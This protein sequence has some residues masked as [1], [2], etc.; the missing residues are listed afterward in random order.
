[1]SFSATLLVCAGSVHARSIADRLLKEDGFHGGLIVYVAPRDAASMIDVATKAPRALIHGLIS[2]TSVLRSTRGDI[3][4][5]GRYGRVSV[6]AWSGPRLPY[7]DGMVNILVMGPAVT[8]EKG[9][10]DR[11]L[12]PG[13]SAWT[14]AGDD[15][16]RYHKP[17]AEG[18]DVWTHVRYDATGN[19]VS[20]DTRSGPPRFLQWEALPRW[21]AGTKT[22]GLVTT[23]GR[24]FYILNDAHFNAGPPTWSLIARDAY[25]GIRLWRHE[26][27]RWPGAREGKKVGPAQVNRR[28]VAVGDRV[29]AT[30]GG[31]A[32]VSVLDAA[33][34]KILRALKDTAQTAEVV[35]SSGVLVALVGPGSDTGMRRETDRRK[36]ALVAVDPG[37]GEL[38]W[39]HD[40]EFIMPLSMASDGNQVVFHDGKSIRSL[41]LKRGTPRWTSP[42]TGQKIEYRKSANPDS[43]GTAKGSIWLAPQFAPTMLI[44]RDVVAFAGG[45]QI[46]VVSAANGKELWR[47]DF[48]ATN[49]SVPVDLFG[50]D[51][52]LWGPDAK[53]NLWRPMDDDISYIA[54]D[55]KTGEIRKRIKGRYRYRFQHHRCH[56]MK[57][58]DGTILASRAGIEYVNMETGDTAAHHWIRGS[59][60][61]GVMPANGLLY[62]PPHNCACYVR[63][64]LSGFMS[65]KSA[66]SE[67]PHEIPDGLR[68][69]KGPALGKTVDASDEAHQDDWPTYRHDMARSGRTDVKVGSD[70]L[71]GW[72]ADPGG[73]LTSPVV[74][75]GRL[76]VASIDVHRLHALDATTGKALWHHDF[77]ARIDSPPTLREGLV[78]C[79]CRDGS[80]HALRAK[81]GA[82]VWRYRVAPTTRMIVSRGQLESVWPV[83][84]SLLV[85]D[86]TVYASA[87]KSSYLDGGIQLVGLELHTGRTRFREVLNSRDE[88][89]DE[90]LDNESVDGYLNDILSSDGERLF[91]RHRVLD[92]EGKPLPE[93]VTHLHGADGFLS[94]DTTPRLIWTYAP[95]YTSRHQGAFYDRR[96][97]RVFFPSGTILVEGED[98]I[99]GFGVNHYGRL[100]ADAGGSAALFAAP[101]TGSVSAD[102]TAREYRALALKRQQLIAFNWWKRVPVRAWAMI[103]AGDMLYVAGSRGR[104]TS[105]ETLDGKEPGGL[106]AVSPKDGRVVADM[107]IPAMPTWDGMAVA[108]GNLYITMAS[109]Q[110]LCLWSANSGKPGHPLEARAEK[111]DMPPVKVEAEQGLT[112]RWRFDEGEG[113]VARDCS[114]RGH[115]AAVSGTWGKDASG[116]YL[117]ADATPD[118]AVLPDAP[119]LQFGNDDFTIAF[120]AKVE[121]F[122]CRLLGKEAFPTEWWVINL[123][124]DGRPEMVIGE[125]KGPGKSVRART[126]S[127]IRKGAWIHLA[128]VVDR[129]SGTVR[130]YIDGTQAGSQSIPPTM[131]RGVGAAGRDIRIPSRHKPFRGGFRDLRIYRQALDEERVKRLAR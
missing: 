78:L 83:S 17:R 63:A 48:A 127:P 52:L 37:N 68:L 47:A 40:A 24:I 96:L 108:G 109:G 103:C 114:G 119:H 123:P 74:G 15:W 62:A 118:A 27:P 7:M 117:V 86:K 101:K 23:N 102:L 56:Q 9:E 126:D 88:K 84:G 131:K 98:A 65:L 124:E 115:D 5:A 50:H 100:T 113:T 66:L 1:M 116:P 42:P 43:P 44:Y 61:Y 21:N 11:I 99:Y 72:K 53:M 110:V 20:R 30:L 71:L 111:A 32:P 51:G 129:K 45:R 57:V 105:R 92:L 106:L 90:R 69:I 59:C 128:V 2:D 87:G 112:G 29:Y 75:G 38:L 79:G 22:S 36:A 120:L 26:L 18:V 6:V 54:Y 46:T 95:L 107:T 89:G 77:D 35:V 64:K 10:V 28:L 91:M 121:A 55:L 93:R 82:L 13:G 4:A 104:T 85:V 80:V 19:A 81:D 94:G 16:S 34:G 8:V 12:V 60:Y 58:V 70:L 14:A 130:W 97:S 3:R 49:Y 122:D 73:R 125:G 76:F 67:K 33:T 39:R 25:N 41:D 31:A